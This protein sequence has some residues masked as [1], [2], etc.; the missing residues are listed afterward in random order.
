MPKKIINE[1]LLHEQ[2]SQNGSTNFI[3]RHIVLDSKPF[4]SYICKYTK[5]FTG[6]IDYHIHGYIF[7]FILICLREQG[8]TETRLTSNS[9]IPSSI[10]L[11]SESKEFCVV[12]RRRCE[13]HTTPHPQQSLP[14]NY[15]SSSVRNQSYIHNKCHED[16]QNG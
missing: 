16:I 2:F 3:H 10:L 15:R 14:H 12:E 8:T 6:T 11:G 1:T 9:I 4:K 5:C 7:P 13:Y